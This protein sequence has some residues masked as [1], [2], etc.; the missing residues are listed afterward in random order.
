MLKREDKIPIANALLNWLGKHPRD[1]GSNVF[2]GIITPFSNESGYTPFEVW[3]GWDLLR[4]TSRI[5]GKYDHRRVVNYTPLESVTPVKRYNKKI[6]ELIKW[7]T[8]KCTDWA[9]NL[10]GDFSY[11]RFSC[12]VCIE[13][14]KREYGLVDSSSTRS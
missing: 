5:Q 9:H 10:D 14:L 6:Q 8:E 7:G 1:C 13:N 2:K 4:Q 11:P 12:P 3:K